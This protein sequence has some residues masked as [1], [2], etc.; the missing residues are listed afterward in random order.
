VDDVIQS[1]SSIVVV[2]T[3]AIIVFGLEI[4]VVVVVRFIRRP[5]GISP[6]FRGGPFFTREEALHVDVLIVTVVW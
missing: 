3:L 4:F 6:F 2:V 1:L 5:S